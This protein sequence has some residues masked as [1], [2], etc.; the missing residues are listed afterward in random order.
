MK[1]II[2]TESQMNY[3]VEGLSFEPYYLKS[4]DKTYKRTK[5]TYDPNFNTQRVDDKENLFN[6]T[7]QINNNFKIKLTDEMINYLNK[8]NKITTDSV[9]NVNWGYDKEKGEI[10]C[11]LSID[12]YKPSAYKRFYIP[13]NSELK[14]FKYDY[15]RNM[16]VIRFKQTPT[17]NGY[18][19]DGIA[20]IPFVDMLARKEV[21]GVYVHDKQKAIDASG[22]ADTQFFDKNQTIRTLDNTKSQIVTLP[23]SRVKCIN[24]FNFNLTS[25]ETNS[26]GYKAFKPMKHSEKSIAR[27]DVQNPHRTNIPSEP[28]QKKDY[29]VQDRSME[30]FYNKI[31]MF[32]SNYV[33]KNNITLFMSPQS[34]SSLN[35]DIINKTKQ[36]LPNGNLIPYYNNLIIKNTQNL[37]IDKEK[38]QQMG[39]DDNYINNLEYRLNLAKKKDSFNIKTFP[40]RERERSVLTNPFIINPQ[41]INNIQKIIN[42]QN[43]ILFDDNYSTGI[44]LDEI[45]LLI[46]QYNP[47]AI[48]A[49][50]IGNIKSPKGSVNF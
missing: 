25:S 36:K 17:N 37:T 50:T 4:G 7:A 28:G 20:E 11:V 19:K 46:K 22:Y 42:N 1:K 48:T 30:V 31:V 8:K 47:K 15:N 9:L 6:K 40:E 41:Y 16:F 21:N 12:K 26:L 23:K 27:N 43:I 44:T 32:L 24:I 38:A 34:S 14:S 3:I 18:N 10:N 39:M 5:M 29:I 2:I 35:S 33:N 45:C 13:Y 49:I